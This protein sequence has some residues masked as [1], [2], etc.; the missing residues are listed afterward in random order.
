M[1]VEAELFLNAAFAFFGN[2]F[3]DLDGIDDHSVWV[4]GFGI[5]GVGEGVV[6][7]VRGLQVSFGN[8]ISSL[9]LGLESD[10]LLIPFLDGGGDSI[11]GHDAT[12]QG[13]WDSCGKVSDQ[14]VWVG[15]VG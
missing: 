8:V 2:E 14:D 11:H 10:G 5:R 1:A 13:W 4:V 6:G 9:P 15:D 12:H 7:L 3:G